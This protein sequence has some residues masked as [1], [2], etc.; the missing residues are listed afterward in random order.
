MFHQQSEADDLV[1]NGPTYAEA[2]SSR[3]EFTLEMMR[4]SITGWQH[5]LEW[6]KSLR[7]KEAAHLEQSNN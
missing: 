3:L 5:E 2:S 1:R 4:H 7:T 6:A